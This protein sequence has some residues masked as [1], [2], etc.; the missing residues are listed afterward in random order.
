[1]TTKAVGTITVHTYSPEAYDTVAG[2]PDLVRVHVE[3][4]F[5]GDIVGTGTA[6]FLQTAQADGAA[7]FVGVERVRGSVAG[8]EGTFV[9]QDAGTVADGVVDGSW[10]VVPGS[11]TGELA[12]LRGTGG[13]RANLGADATIEV[14]YWFE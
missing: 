1:M 8:K 12:G 2:G 9:L 5:A 3:E 11:G 6:T 14:D 13:F 7:S 10:F 4:S